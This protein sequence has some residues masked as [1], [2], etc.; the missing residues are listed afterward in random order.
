VSYE[1]EE[2]HFGSD[3]GGSISKMFPSN[4]YEKFYF[5]G[6]FERDFGSV[7]RFV[8]NNSSD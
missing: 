7:Y 1:Y 5:V 4:R 8:A 6:D 3:S 2:I